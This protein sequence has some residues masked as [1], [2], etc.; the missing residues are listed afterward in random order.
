M[1]VFGRSGLL[2]AANSTPAENNNNAQPS[3]STLNM[4]SIPII[5]DPV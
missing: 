5:S 4:L 2:I 3:L 1:S